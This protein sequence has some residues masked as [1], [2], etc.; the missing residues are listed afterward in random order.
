SVTSE[1]ARLEDILRLATKADRP[2]MTGLLDLRT[3]LILPPGPAKVLDKLKLDGEFGVTNGQWT[4]ADVR[5]KLKSLSRHGEGQPAN[6]TAGSSVSDFRGFFTLEKSTLTFRNLRF[7]VPGADVQLRGDYALR[8]ERLD[9]RGD[10]RM[11]AKLSQTVAGKKS[12]FLK[13]IDPFF[14]KNGT[15]TQL[16]IKIS[17][18]RETPTIGVSI[19]HKTMKRN[20]TEDKSPP[21]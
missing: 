21:N 19:F 9:F 10:L 1:K 6:E 8:S 5:E 14:S 2:F 18:T 16:P 12:F 3:K 20:L 7:S 15:G 13:A 17:G 4:N 11:Q